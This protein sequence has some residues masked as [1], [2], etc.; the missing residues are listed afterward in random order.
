MIVLL[1]EHTRCAVR[2]V[3][4]KNTPT[5]VAFKKFMRRVFWKEN[6]DKKSQIDIV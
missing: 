3:K 1:I 6:Q 4:L 5:F 2:E